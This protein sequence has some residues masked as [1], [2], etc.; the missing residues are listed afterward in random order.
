MVYLLHTYFGRDG[1]EEAEELL[2][3]RSGNPDHPRILSTFNEP[4]EDWLSFFCFTMFTGPRRQVPAAD[5]GRVGLRSAGAH[6]P[7][8]LTEEAHHMF[9]GQTGVGR[10]IERTCQ[11]M[12]E[13]PGRRREAVRR[14]PDDIIQKY[15]NF[16]SSS[17]TDLYGA[18]VSSNSAN[19]FSAGLK[20]ARTRSAIRI[21]RR[22]KAS[23]TS[24]DSSM[25][26]SS[27]EKVPL[28]NAMKRSACATEYVKTTSR[29][30]EYWNRIC[31]KYG[32]RIGSRCRHR[33]FNRK[34]G[35]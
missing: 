14:D 22:S 27:P 12:K 31:E 34:I 3:R 21:T 19:F 25:E 26:S 23:T 17:S 32:N 29:G 7:F 28:R 4:C 15:I 10:V 13:H 6:V 24:I 1:R 18:E 11:V 9:V 20:G 35:D 33:W 2:Q 16:W 8:M 30:I 5:A